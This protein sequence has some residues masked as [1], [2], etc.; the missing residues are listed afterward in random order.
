[1][2]SVSLAF[3]RG[4]GRAVACALDTPQA[5]VGGLQRAM[6]VPLDIL[7]LYVNH[8]Q[9]VSMKM[10]GFVWRVLPLPFRRCRGPQRAISVYFI[11]LRRRVQ[12]NAVH[13]AP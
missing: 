3:F 1:M 9:L 6:A 7:V 11:W 5:R 4:K 8:A 12:P 10:K 13:R 2:H